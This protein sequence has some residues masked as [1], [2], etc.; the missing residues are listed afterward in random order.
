MFY[1]IPTMDNKTFVKQASANKSVEPNIIFLYW[2]SISVM[3]TDSITEA[4]WTRENTNELRKPCHRENSYIS[5]VEERKE[6]DR[7]V[8]MRII[9]WILPSGK[10]RIDLKIIERSVEA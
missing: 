1:L 5:C 10:S 7:E 6:L 2:T 8:I 3:L 4:Y 9:R